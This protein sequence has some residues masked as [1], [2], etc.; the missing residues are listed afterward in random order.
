MKNCLHCDFESP[1][2]FAFC[3]KCGTSLTDEQKPDR[4]VERLKRLAPRGYIERLLAMKSKDA[5][6]RKVV[7][8]L[9]CDVA[10]ST[11][12]S[13][14]LDPEDVMEIMDKAFDFLI[15]PIIRYE[16]T[17]A[18]LMGDGMLAFFGAPIA[19]EDDPERACRA[20]LDIMEGIKAYAEELERE[21]GIKCFDVRVGI[22]TGLVVMGE[23]GSD[24]R[25]EYTAMGNAINIAAR[26]ESAAEPGTVLVTNDTHKLIAPLFETES[27]GQISIKGKKDPINAYRVLASSITSSKV[28]GIAG[29]ESPLVGREN[30]FT[31]L[32]E[33]LIGLEKGMGRIA[34]VV[35][36]AGIGKS[37]L[38]AELRKHTIEV[39]PKPSQ[40]L[41]PLLWVEGRCFS[42]SSSIAYTLWIDV[43]RGLLNVT[44]EDDPNQ[45]RDVLEERLMEY[46]QD[47]FMMSTLI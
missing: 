46:C 8:V 9:F 2:D 10:G 14:S 26:M 17:V 6:E 44:T 24:L 31:A 4:I 5:G 39:N 18:R 34:T 42:Y 32:Q 15:E 3:P 37:R 30:K 25:V 36:E 13:E 47:T 35:G 28:R 21:R 40:M 27:L 29:M 38:I 19:H 45:V 16:G 7:T 22:N 43:L 41:D 12:M 23:V 20:A 1:T 11:S 33:A